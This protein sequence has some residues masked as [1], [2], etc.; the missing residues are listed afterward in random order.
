MSTSE[1]ENNIPTLFEPDDRPF[2]VS[3]AEWT[4]KWWKWWHSG[5]EEP[6]VGQEDETG[7]VFFLTTKKM[8]RYDNQVLQIHNTIP[9]DKAILFP[10][11]K[12]ISVGLAFTPDDQLKDVAKKRIDMLPVVSIS[13]DGISILPHRVQSDVFKIELK[14]DI[15]NPE[16]PSNSKKIVKGK[17]KAVG[18]GYW[19]FLKP[20]SLKNGNH[21]MPAFASCE[22]GELSLNVHHTLNII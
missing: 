2:G 9:R 6:L 1:V 12:W 16:V 3:Y 19:I 13:I 11:D 8:E 20:N 22:T 7:N 21:E 18:E 17:Y 5:P 15:P 14:R 4:A 10:V